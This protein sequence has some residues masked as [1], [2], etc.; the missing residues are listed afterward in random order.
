[1]MRLVKPARFLPRSP[2]PPL[3]LLHTS[4]LFRQVAAEAAPAAPKAVPSTAAPLVEAEVDMY[5]KSVR[6]LHW[7]MAAGILGAMGS[8]HLA[9]RTQGEEKK[10]WLRVHN[11]CGTVVALTIAP[12]MAIRSGRTGGGGWTQMRT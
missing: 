4:R 3:R 12:R 6:V 2:L 7:V 8:V 1:M 10:R 5:A 9:Y 11:T